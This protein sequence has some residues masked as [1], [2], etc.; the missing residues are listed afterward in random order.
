M[1]NKRTFWQVEYYSIK[2]NNGLISFFK[3]SETILMPFVHLQPDPA[4]SLAR[5][6]ARVEKSANHLLYSPAI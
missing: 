2:L 1:K 5:I 4:S 3:K 6:L